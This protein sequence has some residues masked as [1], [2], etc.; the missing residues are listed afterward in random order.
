MN[1]AF[2]FVINEQNGTLE[3]KSFSKPAEVIS[4]E[5]DQKKYTW[6][7]KRT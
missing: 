3:E 6:T 5:I 2:L 1:F 4:R 7:K